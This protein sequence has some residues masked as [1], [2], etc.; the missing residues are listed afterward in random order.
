MAGVGRASCRVS[1]AKD[2]TLDAT[3]E[4]FE[5]RTSHGAPLLFLGPQN[6]CERA[7]RDDERHLSGRFRL[8]SMGHRHCGGINRTGDEPNRLA[9]HNEGG[10]T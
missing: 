8:R 9:P 10:Q 7:H 1:G 4:P 5:R 2:D 6:P 3:V